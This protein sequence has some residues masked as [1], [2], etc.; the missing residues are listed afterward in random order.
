MGDE[1]RDGPTPF[2]VDWTD[3]PSTH[4]SDQLEVGRYRPRD[5][6]KVPTVWH[7]GRPPEVEGSTGRPIEQRAKPFGITFATD[8]RTPEGGRTLNSD[9]TLK[10]CFNKD[11]SIIP[12]SLASA[13]FFH[14]QIT[15]Q[16]L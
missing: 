9:V 11:C 2:L 14:H 13:E 15:R 5:F 16:H 1:Q 6:K 4:H 3:G 10:N 12:P 7:F 8:L